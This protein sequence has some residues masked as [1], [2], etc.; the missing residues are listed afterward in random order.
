MKGLIF[1]FDN[2]LFDSKGL[3]R[4]AFQNALKE[5]GYY[6]T[7]DMERAYEKRDSG[8]RLDYMIETRRIKKDDINL[9]RRTVDNITADM[10]SEVKFSERAFEILENMKKC[11]IK[12]AIVS[13]SSRPPIISFLKWT[14]LNEVVDFVTASESEDYERN[15]SNADVY[16]KTLQKMSLD[17]QDVVAFE[18]TYFGSVAAKLAG[19]ENI[20]EVSDH[21]LEPA[22]EHLVR[23]FE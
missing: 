19:I 23:T 22:L 14:R 8:S 13:N 11:G 16:T 20:R 2:V 7:P 1:S 10:M 17:P 6:W 18:G 5:H 12:I 21:S 4:R 9:V 3:R 15:K